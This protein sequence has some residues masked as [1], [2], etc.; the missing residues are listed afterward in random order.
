MEAYVYQRLQGDNTIRVLELK[1]S[2]DQDDQLHGSFITASLEKAPAFDALSY[3]WGLDP[4]GNTI[5]IEGKEIGIRPNLEAAL[6]RLRPHDKTALVWADALCINQEDP[7]ERN[8]QVQIMADI[9]R[10][11]K[12]TVAW[13]GKGDEAQEAALRNLSRIA[14]SAPDF[15]Y[16]APP[17]AKITFQIKTKSDLGYSKGNPRDVLVMAAEARTDLIYKNEWFTRLWIVQETVLAKEIVVYL[18]DSELEW[19]VLEV[20][21]R[22]LYNA[23]CG[24]GEPFPD[25]GEI[26]D[27]VSLMDERKHQFLYKPPAGLDTNL[28]PAFNFGGLN[29]RGVLDSLL[30]NPNSGWIPGQSQLMFMQDRAPRYLDTLWSLRHR[31]C[32]D[33]RDRV[34]AARSFIPWDVRIKVEVDYGRSIVQVYTDFTRSLLNARVIKVLLL[35]GIWDRKTVLPTEND[36]PS[37]V[38][39]W[40]RSELERGAGRPWRNPHNQEED[41]DDQDIEGMETWGISPASDP[42]DRRLRI[43]LV[44]VDEVERVD[45]PPTWA[46]FDLDMLCRCL[47]GRLAVYGIAKNMLANKLP[48]YEEMAKFAHALG[49]DEKRRPGAVTRLA[50]LSLMGRLIVGAQGQP[51]DGSKEVATEEWHISSD[52]PTEISEADEK[53]VSSMIQRIANGNAFFSTKDGWIGTGPSMVS[54]GDILV[55]IMGILRPFILRK[56][57]GKDEHLLV[58]ACYMADDLEWR[59]QSLE[60]VTLV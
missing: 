27:V 7:D 15:G 42:Y 21:I 1:P 12:R 32:G 19:I 60:R 24:L 40:R 13:L 53:E 48:S 2:A 14:D 59:S 16:D 34:Y 23:I 35:A 41:E 10:T 26:E 4:P 3:V 25:A 43:E 8:S 37:W 9:Y 45:A 30:H 29:S 44:K 54:S 20:A 51:S 11:A 38:C 6:R 22:L 17:E 56:G 36:P 52:Y 46:G 47:Y 49:I 55:R 39:E 31:N 33:A 57:Q 18:G 58:G 5:Q 50:Q 28:L